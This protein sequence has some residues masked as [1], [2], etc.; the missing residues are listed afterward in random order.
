MH[1]GSLVAAATMFTSL[2]VIKGA[3]LCFFRGKVQQAGWRR[4]LILEQQGCQISTKYGNNF[5]ALLILLVFDIF[6]K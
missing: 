2:P 3:D 5:S 4:I 1:Y 6:S